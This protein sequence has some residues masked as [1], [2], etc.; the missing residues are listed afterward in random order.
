MRKTYWILGLLFLF[1]S[2]IR[3]DYHRPYVNM[4][5]E[6]RLDVDEST[7]LCNALWWDNFHDEVLS[8]LIA[9]AIRNNQDIHVAISR[10][11]EFYDRLRVIS[12][13]QFPQITANGGYTRYQS[14]LDLPG[15][16]PAPGVPRINND[17]LA[18]LNL[19]WQ[20]DFYGQFQNATY[21]A[22]ADLIGQVEAR[23]AVVMTVVANVASSYFTLR[24]LDAQLTVSRMT[25][26]SRQEALKLAEDRFHL[27]ETSELEVIQSAAEVEIAAI[28]VLEF[29]RDIPQQENLLSILIG[30][31]PHDMPRGL[32][33]EQLQYEVE[34]PAGLPSELLARRPDIVRAE[35][36]IIAANARVAEARALFFP[37]ITLTGN[38]GNES[39]LL[40]NFLSSSA[41]FWQ[42]GLNGV[43]TILDFGKTWYTVEEREAL[44]DETVFAYRQVIL[45]ALQE[46]NSALVAVR[47]DKELVVENEKQVQILRKYLKLATL[48]Y[49]EGEIDY[50]NVLDAMNQLFNAELQYIIS[51]S[52]RLI[53]IVTLYNALGGGWVDDA[54]SLAIS[55]DCCGE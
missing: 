43:Q 1:T 53:S 46:V 16:S 15:T 35:Q 28:R 47:K 39:S 32:Q 5:E 14:S 10:V 44:R 2:C 18:Q 31:N 8:D 19:S 55:G 12:S 26:K 7:T 27:G 45:T 41:V 54:D 3:P 37:Q 4:P 17:F 50:L 24:A 40:R 22:Y 20:L 30:E 11:I 9:S 25:L 49:D 21:A 6:W 48:R 36:A 34:I 42:F 23:R 13:Q 38:F 29:E 33:I 51:Q 52:N